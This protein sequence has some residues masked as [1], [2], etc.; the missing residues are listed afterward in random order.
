MC[1]PAP[2]GEGTISREQSERAVRLFCSVSR[3]PMAT[4]RRRRQRRAD[5][6]DQKRTASGH[7]GEEGEGGGLCPLDSVFKGYSRLHPERLARGELC[8]LDSVF[9]GFWFFNDMLVRRCRR[10]LPSNLWDSWLKR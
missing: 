7:G 2:R 3:Y 1:C 10:C 6:P 4:M 8:P 5:G 9:K